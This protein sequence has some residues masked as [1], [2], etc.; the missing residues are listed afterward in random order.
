MPKKTKGYFIRCEKSIKKIIEKM[1]KEEKNIIERDIDEC[2]CI[3]KYDKMKRV[4]EKIEE[5][6]TQFLVEPNDFEK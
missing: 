5:F 3:I 2:T 1:D 4:L 6:Q